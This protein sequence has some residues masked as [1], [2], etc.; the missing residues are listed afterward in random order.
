MVH[1]FAE[2]SQSWYAWMPYLTRNYRVILF[3][4]RGYGKST[5]MPIDFA[6]TMDCLL[7]DISLVAK[8]FL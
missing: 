7:N 1:G 3:D 4:M 5:A 6:W 2:S 8:H